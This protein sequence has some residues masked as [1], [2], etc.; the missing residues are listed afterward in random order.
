MIDLFCLFALSP[1]SHIKDNSSLGFF[2]LLVLPTLK[3]DLYEAVKISLPTSLVILAVGAERF[4]GYVA[5]QPSP[6]GLADAVPDVLIQDAPP[7]VVAQPGAAVCQRIMYVSKTPERVG[8]WKSGGEG[9]G[10]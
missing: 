1:R 10:G 2:L 5:S 8:T 3:D 7:V 6:P 4:R 9:G